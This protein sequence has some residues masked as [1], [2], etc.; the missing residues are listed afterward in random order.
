MSTAHGRVY[1][2]SE[3]C[4]AVWPTLIAVPPLSVEVESAKTPPRVVRKRVEYPSARVRAD[5]GQVFVLA[6]KIRPRADEHERCLLTLLPA[7]SE[8]GSAAELSIRLVA[9]I[10][11]LLE[12]VGGRLLSDDDVK[13]LQHEGRGK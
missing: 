5:G 8:R 1:E 9:H 3:S 4:F 10:G 7:P 13:A 6:F 12:S 11:A 2:V